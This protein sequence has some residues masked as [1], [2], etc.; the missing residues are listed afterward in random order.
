MKQRNKQ[1]KAILASGI[2]F[3]MLLALLGLFDMTMA[4]TM[5]AQAQ[6]NRERHAEVSRAESERPSVTM[7]DVDRLSL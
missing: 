1:I 4:A 3:L 6:K 7:Q 2:V 5:Q